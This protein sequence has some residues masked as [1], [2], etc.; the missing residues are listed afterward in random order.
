LKRR[1]KTFGTFGA[2]GTFVAL[3]ASACLLLAACTDN[4]SVQFPKL[5]DETPVITLPGGASATP[6]AAAVPLALSV[7]VPGTQE[8]LEAVAALFAGFSSGTLAKDAMD[9]DTG[10]LGATISLDELTRFQSLLTLRIVETPA[11]DTLERALLTLG[12]ANALPDVYMTDALPALVHQGFTSPLDANEELEILI[13]QGRCLPTALEACILDGRLHAVPL[14][15]SSPILFYNTTLTAE[16]G[17]DPT[18]LAAGMQMKDFAALLPLLTDSTLKQVALFD[19]VPLMALLPATKKSRPGWATY[20]DGSFSFTSSAF[21]ETVSSLRSIVKSQWTLNH[22]TA[23]QI[24]KNY[25]TTD[26][27]LLGKVAFWIEDSSRIAFWNT[28]TDVQVGY[29]ALPYLEVQTLPI[30]LHALCVAPTAED[31]DLAARFAA[32]LA[33][34]A[35]SLRLQ[36]RLG[37]V[38]GMVPVVT[39]PTQWDECTQKSPASALLSSFLARLAGASFEARIGTKGWTDAIDASLGE[40]A[41]RLLQGLDSVGAV[42]SKMDDAAQA[43][44]A[45]A[46]PTSAAG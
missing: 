36:A 32:F 7:C 29:A 40:H 41:L 19:A 14:S 22:L 24:V 4:A 18:L 30:H 43:A 20:S 16:A 5:E 9:P 34:D 21:T 10:T 28:Q 8:S 11:A 17:I 12:A 31:P 26:P 33:V 3:V 38:P 35:D 2:F 45:A 39:E 25:G 13:R 6:T 37:F 1:G 44:I 23:E 46:S 27:R 42:A 15:A